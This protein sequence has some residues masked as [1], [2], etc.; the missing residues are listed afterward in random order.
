MYRELA[1]WWPLLSAP[2][3]YADEA[4]EYLTA[5]RTHARR[6]IG[7]V[8]E[9]GCGGG[10]NASHLK[11]SVRLTLVDRSPEMLDVS[12]ALNPECEHIE[13][14]MRT[15]RLGRDF[16]AVLIHDAIMY[17]LTDDDLRAAIGTAAAHLRSGGV[18][19][20][21]PDDTIESFRPRT[22]SG[23]HD[24]EMGRAM[25]WLSWS[26]APS[27]G[28]STFATTFVY[29]LVEG[30]GP[31]R[32]E[33]EEHV[34]S[35]FRRATWLRLIDDEGLSATAVSS[36]HWSGEPDNRHEFFVGVAP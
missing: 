29:V 36:E 31:A 25:R 16:D 28:S 12:R 4:R 2:S 7:E 14:D 6:E 30:N 20:F 24:G 35:L 23:G 13:G 3:E 17:M 10:N 22:Q 32:V 21:V 26:R 11:G 27:P 1:A 15:V 9:L 8:L 5:I 19:V 33:H 34:M 18:A